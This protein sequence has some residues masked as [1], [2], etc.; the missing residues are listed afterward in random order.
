MAKSTRLL[1]GVAVGLSALCLVHCLALPLV[2]AGL[3]FLAQFAE[4]HLHA[5]MLVI[6]L[7]LSIVALGLGYRHHRNPRIL[8]AGF[9]GMALL[10]IGAIIAHDRWG[11]FADRAFTI[12]GA[13]VLAVAHFY[14]SIQTRDRR[15]SAS[16]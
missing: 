8:V 1:D 12:A 3:P 9:A 7:P 16:S 14:N 11:L 6:V 13:L 2:V 15:T 4:G 5:Q 10:T